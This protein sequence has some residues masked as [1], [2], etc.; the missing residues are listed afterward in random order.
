MFDINNKVA[1][2]WVGVLEQGGRQKAGFAIVHK[3]RMVRTWPDA[4]HPES[5]FGQAQGSNDLVNQRLVGEIYL[6][7]FDVS[8]T[9][10]DIHW[11]DDEEDQIQ[12]K[13]QEACAEYRDV[14]R[15]TRKGRRLAEAAVQAAAREIESELQSPEMQDIVTQDPPEPATVAADDEALLAETDISNVDFQAVLPGRTPVTVTGILDTT[16][17]LH[18][19]YVI[20]ESSTADHVLVIINMNHPHLGQIDENGLLNYFRHC[21]YDALAEWRARNQAQTIDPSTIRRLK[22]GLLR[23][24]LDIAMHED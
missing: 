6:D 19:P 24:S 12:D 7:D 20:S 22:D 11:M 17:S 18:D 3:R 15:H 21:T 16:K 2:G 1:L 10:D 5:I 8:H 4:W 13:L 23:V 9:K 14:A